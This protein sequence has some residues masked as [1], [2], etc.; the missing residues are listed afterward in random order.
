MAARGYYVIGMQIPPIPP[1]LEEIGR[2]HFSFYPPI[3]G[4]EHNEWMYSSATWSEIRVINAQS[5]AEIWIPRRFLGEVSRVDEPILIVGLIR[6]LEFK[7]GSV[8][9]HQRR[10][11]EM[12]IAVNDSRPRT[13]TPHPRLAPVVNIRTEA[14]HDSRTGRLVV[15]VV[16][17]GVVAC[18]VILGIARN[19]RMRPRQDYSQADQSYLQLNRD[20]DYFG[21][22][23]KLGRPSGER[24]YRAPGDVVYQALRYPG[25]RFDVVLMGR[26]TAEARYL[27]AVDFGHQVLDSARLPNGGEGAAMLRALPPF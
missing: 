14:S 13:S 5:G 27:G 22:L 16:V 17:L 10:V 1:H 25:R 19:S 23:R 11:I 4:I 3:L 7:L 15:G 20:D 9:P 26:T 12:P 24:V 18:S 6:E 21:V 8:W 2:R